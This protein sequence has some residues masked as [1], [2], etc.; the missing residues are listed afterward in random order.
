[1]LFLGPV[2]RPDFAA[3]LER[4]FSAAGIRAAAGATDA[5]LDVAEEVPYN[6]QLLA[7]ACW[8]T[9]RATGRPLTS[10]LVL[11]TRNTVAL[12]ND[13]LYTQLWSSLAAAQQKALVALIREGGLQLTSTE[14]AR[15]YDVPVPTMQK[16]LRALEAKGILREEQSRGTTRLR[17]EDPL[18]GVWVDLVVPR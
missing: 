7:H 1:V 4:G 10:E 8:D 6:V 5:I 16:A 3:F 18:F 14:V 13:P 2:P 17:L 11:E 15:R 12:R 9:C